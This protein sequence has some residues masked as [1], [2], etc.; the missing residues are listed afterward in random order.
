M[1]GNLA[2]TIHPIFD[3]TSPQKDVSNEKR[4]FF[5]SIDGNKVVSV[6]GP[7]TIRWCLTSSSSFQSLVL[8]SLPEQCK[9][10]T[11]STSGN[12]I[13]FYTDNEINIIEVP[14]GYPGDVSS[15]KYMFHV[16]NHQFKDGRTIKQI[17]FHPRAHR[18]SCVVVLFEDD[19]IAMVNINTK[20]NDDSII[21]LN[22]QDASLGLES[23][24]TKIATMQFSQDGLSLY[25]LSTAEGGDIYTFYPCLPNSLNLEYNEIKTLFNKSMLLYKDINENT[26][27]DIKRNIIKTLQFLELLKK[28]V[29]KKGNQNTA[30]E[31]DKEYQFV[32]AQ[33]PF[34]ISPYPEELYEHTATDMKVM[35]IKN[36]QSLLLIS[37][38]NGTILILFQDLELTMSWDVANFTNNNSLV[39]IEQMLLESKKIHKLENLPGSTGKIICR[40]SQNLSLIDTS[41]WSDEF[42]SIIVNS[43]MNK[44]MNLSITSL[45]ETLNIP[46]SVTSCFM[47][48][49]KNQ[50]TH[51]FV[52]PKMVYNLN[53]GKGKKNNT[54]NNFID[55]SVKGTDE[56]TTPTS[57]EL[58]FSKPLSEI[59]EAEKL[60]QK[61]LHE[62]STIDIPYKLRSEKLQN[63]TNE[64][65]LEVLTEISEKYAKTIAHGQNAAFNY[66][67][68]IME[69]VE[70]FQKQIQVINKLRER[71]KEL[72]ER[73]AIQENRYETTKNRQEKL[74]AR[75]EKFGMKV[76]QA[77]NN[78]LQGDTEI[79]EAENEWFK[80]IKR[81]VLTF[82][83][84]VRQT[85]ATQEELNYIKNQISLNTGNT[86][87]QVKNKS[88]EGEWKQLQAI[89]NEDLQLISSCGNEMKKITSGI[90]TLNV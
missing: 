61:S 8:E 3:S 11:S 52:D 67:S 16:Y 34:S 21:E 5:S 84:Y 20:P 29:V 83:K 50:V 48:S 31:I 23:R 2:K 13:C 76:E 59:K 6:L 54:K 57:Y 24:V 40:G 18:D 72:D 38:S 51:Y 7:R 63:E 36:D 64:N 17:L 87:A 70:Q 1:Q 65:Q 90:N 46:P 56:E 30:I 28:Q 62:L 82:N 43:D 44:L 73:R 69:D 35:P 88:S 12:Y 49:E 80:E 66:N 89:L 9:G 15:M 42:S 81:Y 58:S 86:D 4:Y 71:C 33:G 22:G 19:T 78:I 79:T 75:L 25:L 45:V 53:S 26:S 60:F 39:L 47:W 85:K 10:V 74:A 27:S 41:N 37:F 77:S 32:K 55:K 68:R 14:W